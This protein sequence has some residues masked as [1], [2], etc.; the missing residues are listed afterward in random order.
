MAAIAKKSRQITRQHF[1]TSRL[2]DF[3]SRGDRGND[4]LLGNSNLRFINAEARP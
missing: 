2:L 1:E 4:N 3:L